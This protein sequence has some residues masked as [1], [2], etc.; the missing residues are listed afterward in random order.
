MDEQRQ[1]GSDGRLKRLRVL[2]SRYA[3]DIGIAFIALTA[4]VLAYTWLRAR[5]TGRI[6]PEWGI[7]PGNHGPWRRN[8]LGEAVRL[9]WNL[10]LAGAAIALVSAAIWPNKRSVVIAAIGSGISL[11]VL[12]TH[13]WLV[14]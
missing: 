10:P 9:A 12:F 11:L 3:G 7:H 14:D 8:E 5:Q 6:P 4:I 1:I 2:A 13:L